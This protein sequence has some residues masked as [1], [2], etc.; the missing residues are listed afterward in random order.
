MVHRKGRFDVRSLGL[1]F[2]YWL[3]LT[4]LCMFAGPAL[5]E[6]QTLL[7]HSHRTIRGDLASEAKNSYDIPIVIGQYVRLQQVVGSPAKQQIEGS[8]TAP[9]TVAWIAPGELA[10]ISAIGESEGVYRLDVKASIS[11]AHGQYSITVEAIR[12]ALTN[13]RP[14]ITQEPSLA[15]QKTPSGAEDR[16]L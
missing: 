2:K 8:K 15:R 14:Y 4:L 3:S 7:V 10:Y 12:N 13:D 9:A 1:R 5:A 6:T 16:S 11:G